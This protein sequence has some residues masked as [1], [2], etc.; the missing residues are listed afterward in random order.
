VE[1]LYLG[2]HSTERPTHHKAD[3]DGISR[4]PAPEL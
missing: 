3:E 4:L 2:R 1:V